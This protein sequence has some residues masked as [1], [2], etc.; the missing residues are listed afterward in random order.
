MSV[1][2]LSPWI[3]G[4]QPKKFHHTRSDTIS[5]LSPYQTIPCPKFHIGCRLGWELFTLPYA[6]ID[7]HGVMGCDQKKNIIILV[8][9]QWHQLPTQ[10]TLV[11]WVSCRRGMELFTLPL[12]IP[13]FTF[14]F[15]MLCVQVLAGGDACPAGGSHT[16][17]CP[18]SRRLDLT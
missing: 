13:V 17:C 9:W 11:S 12:Y 7:A 18:A 3:R 5:C 6:A 15:A 8:V 2:P 14:L 4:L 10:R 16:R 1:L